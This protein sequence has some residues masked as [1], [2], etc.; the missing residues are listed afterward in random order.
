MKK[1]DIEYIKLVLLKE[2]NQKKNEFEE[3]KNIDLVEEIEYI[4]D[5]LERL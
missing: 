1:E 5:L 4:K 3:T 2:L